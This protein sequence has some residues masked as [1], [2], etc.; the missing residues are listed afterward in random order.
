MST[1]K[2]LLDR[3]KN[4][5]TDFEID[6]LDRLMKQLHCEKRTRG[7]TSGSAIAYVHIPT[8]RTWN[9]HSPHPENYLKK[10]QMKSVLKFLNDVGE[11]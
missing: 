2:K 1:K 4:L 10:Y 5:P 3:L 9:A 6:E 7:A 8:K 11:I